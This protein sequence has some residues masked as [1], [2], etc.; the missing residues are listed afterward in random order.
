MSECREVA[1]AMLPRFL[2]ENPGVKFYVK[3]EAFVNHLMAD[4][5]Y[6]VRDT[7]TYHLHRLVVVAVD[8]NPEYDEPRTY[9][10]RGR[11]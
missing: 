9:A 3:V 4:E 11:K 1:E 7:V 2:Q 6:T 5:S 8:S 10:E